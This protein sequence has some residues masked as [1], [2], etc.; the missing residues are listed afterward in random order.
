M[1]Y[2]FI[3]A[4]LVLLLLS[5]NDEE[6]A[7]T[8]NKP[9]D[10][11][12]YELKGEVKTVK[13]TSNEVLNVKMEPGETKHENP[14]EHNKEMHFNEEGMLILEKKNTSA[15]GPFEQTK[16][17]GREHKTEIIQFVNN[18]PGIK[19]EL[20][21]DE[22]G[23]LNT[24][25]ARRNPDN[26]QI[27]RKVMRYEKGLLAEKTS[28][29]QVDNPI[30]RVTYEYDKKGNLLVEN[31]YL[32]TEYIQIKNAYQYDNKNRKK[33]E[34]RYDKDGNVLYTTRYEYDGDKLSLKEVTNKDG[35]VEYSEKSV[36]DKKG[37]LL[38]KT[39]YDNFDKSE[40]EELYTYDDKGNKLTFAVIKNGEPALKM[41]YNY[42]E[43]GSLSETIITDGAGNPIDS[44]K[45]VF[46]YDEK[47]NWT[48][49]IIFINEKPQF[50]EKRE[51]TYY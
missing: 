40:T 45:Y 13:H 21:W 17:N 36:Y 20:A 24:Q 50:I 2:S 19:T 23:K 42:D 51:I 6:K 5:C 25:I 34:K 38:T 11:D 35:E 7:K 9:T 1:K 44:R 30:D 15:G 8:E 16:Y 4:A 26:S 32:G 47:G 39:S 18:A 14:A 28:Y 22:T 41:S 46:K 12:F 33:A 29:N 43:K 49:K 3:Y 31:L 37:N 10:R 48:E 27:D